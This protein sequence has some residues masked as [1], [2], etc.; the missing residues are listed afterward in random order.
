MIGFLASRKHSRLRGLLSAYIDGEVSESEAGLVEQHLAGCDRCRA[1]LDSLRMTVGLLREL[2]LLAVPRSFALSE[3]PASVRPSRPVFWA[4]PL[5]TSVA[6]LLLVALLVSDLTGIVTQR[7]VVPEDAAAM[8]LE[9]APAAALPLPASA[10][11]PAAAPAPAAMSTPSPLPTPAP[12]M[13]LAAAPPPSVEEAVVAEEVVEVEAETEVAAAQ[14]AIEPKAAEADEEIEMES[15]APRSTAPEEEEASPGVEG[16]ADQLLAEPQMAEAAA[17]VLS[18]ATVDT[19]A[20]ERPQPG[21]DGSQGLS[22]PLWQL[23]VGLG[24]LFVGL[25]LLTLW[26]LRRRHRPSS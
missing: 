24:G 17:P 14:A 16:A 9:A 1:E 13:A 15:M 20:T 10:A 19:P 21:A 25:A 5:T 2:P 6:A 4:V 18:T 26:M 11:V 8:T 22:A 23:E 7:A 12:S 3:E